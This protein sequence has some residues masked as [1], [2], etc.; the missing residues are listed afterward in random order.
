MFD[1]STC[2][3]DPANC[4]LGNQ[5]ASWDTKYE[6]GTKAALLLPFSPFVVAADENEQIR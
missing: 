3:L 5:I 1:F 4:K 2:I 6:T